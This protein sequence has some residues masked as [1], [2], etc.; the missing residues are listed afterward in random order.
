M[1]NILL[2][3]TF[4]MIN[5]AVQAN[6]GSKLIRTQKR[7][8]NIIRSAFKRAKITENEYRKLMNEQQIIKKYI[9]I[10]NADHYWNS[11]EIKRV[12]GKLDRAE[13]RLRKYKT[14]GE[15]Y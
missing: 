8:E 6:N 10:A 1:K 14:N 5:V 2:F 3:T 12:K 11:A 9:D 13:N 15:I 7:Q 4:L